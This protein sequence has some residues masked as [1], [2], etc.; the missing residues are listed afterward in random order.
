MF[1]ETIEA[2][3]AQ[4]A[5]VQ[6]LF[7]GNAERRISRAADPRY[8]RRVHECARFMAEVY[9]GQRPIHHLKE[10]MSTSDF[11]LLFGNVVDRQV[12]QA[13]REA[14]AV[15]PAFVRRVVKADFREA[16][17]TY[18][19]TGGDN[20]L[21]RVGELAEYPERAVSEAQAPG[22][23]VYKHG[24][25]MAFSWEMAIN[26]NLDVMRTLPARLGV[27]ARDTENRLVSELYLDVNGPHAAMFNNTNGNLINTAN[28]ATANNPALSIA[29]LQDAFRILGRRVDPVTGRPI[30][31]QAA[32]LVVPPS[33]E[34]VAQNILNATQ[35]EIT[36]QGGTADQRL[37]T[38]NWMRNRVRL[39]VD[40]YIPIVATG[41]TGHTS[42]FLF[43]DPNGGDRPAL[44]IAFLRGNEEPELRMK[45]PNSRRVAGGAIDPLDGD[46]DT[47]AIQ[48][49]VRHV[50]GGNR[51]DPIM[52]L[53]S[54]G[55]GA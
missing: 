35:L 18:Q 22:Y 3:A 29:G 28:G 10:A 52:A 25:R 50:V 12:L 24:A 46:F 41:A 53:A 16:P 15:W 21:P 47:D 11:P 9:S 34:I 27:A 39:I 33:L 48:Y 36:A 51:I 55:S 54:N 14:P 6:S 49:R 43:A 20:R 4:D 17:T 19:L 44:E 38:A 8:V 42:W 31:I 23:R 7:G 30:V 1:E 13:Y 37:I 40:P 45:E 32:M 5:T 26:D 2:V